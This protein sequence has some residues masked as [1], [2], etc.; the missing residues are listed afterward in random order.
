MNPRWWASVLASSSNNHWTR[1]VNP[2]NS[3]N[4]RNVNSNGDWNNNYVF[5]DFLHLVSVAPSVKTE[6]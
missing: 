5:P 6:W 4:F 2:S 3:T 1:S